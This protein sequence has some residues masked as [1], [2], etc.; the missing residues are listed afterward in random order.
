MSACI[1]HDDIACLITPIGVPK[2][3]HKKNPKK[4]V[5]ELN[6]R[7]VIVSGQLK[8]RDNGA[9]D[10]T[11][12]KRILGDGLGL[13]GRNDGGAGLWSKFK[14]QFVSSSRWPT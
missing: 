10:E 13:G 5:F 9:D 14:W 6:A 8:R 2:K 4:A 7:A 1:V 11:F 3:Q 12:T